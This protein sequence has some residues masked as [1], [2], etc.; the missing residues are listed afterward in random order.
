VRRNSKAVE[1]ICKTQ[2]ENVWVRVFRTTTKNLESQIGKEKVNLIVTSP[3]YGEEKN[4]M[5]YARFSKLALYWLGL[6][7][8][9]V[10]EMKNE[11]LGS[12]QRQWNDSELPSATLQEKLAEIACKNKK[13]AD[14]VYSFFYDYAACLKAMFDALK[15]DSYCCIVIGDRTASGMPI[16]NGIITSELS[17]AIGYTMTE[18]LE[19]KMYMRALRSNI[20]GSENIL[21]MKKV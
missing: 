9:Q 15:W 18:R 3:P 12:S 13:R 20:I 1:T 16:P 11:A 6:D 7:G 21:I 14:E 19:R 10:R 5:D 8:Q 2:N 4:T 17:N